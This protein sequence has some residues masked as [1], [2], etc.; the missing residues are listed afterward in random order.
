MLDREWEILG[1]A[2]FVADEPR[3]SVEP[4]PPFGR[5]DLLR[6]DLSPEYP[7][8]EVSPC[9][10]AHCFIS[11]GNARREGSAGAKQN[12]GSRLVVRTENRRKLT[13]ALDVGH[14]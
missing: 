7:F 10:A 14:L 1:E 12:G 2:V 8:G 3:L 13:H 5:L 11:Q 9:H 4:S 6:Q